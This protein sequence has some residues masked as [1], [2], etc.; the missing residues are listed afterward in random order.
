MH[1]SFEPRVLPTDAWKQ[2]LAELAVNEGAIVSQAIEDA[3]A[4]ACDVHVY[5]SPTSPVLGISLEPGSGPNV[6]VW[7]H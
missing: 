7:E 2:R 4:I 3:A 5:R 6:K 1:L